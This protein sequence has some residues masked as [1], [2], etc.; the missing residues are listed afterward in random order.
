MLKG[1]KR[2]FMMVGLSLVL[3]AQ[4][5]SIGVFAKNSTDH[6]DGTKPPKPGGGGP[7]P[8]HDSK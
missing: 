5:A 1:V 2:V 7:P 4:I 8:I 3:L 6:S